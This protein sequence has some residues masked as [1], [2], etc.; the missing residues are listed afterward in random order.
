MIKCDDCGKKFA[1]KRYLDQHKQ[2]KTPCT[3]RYT[4]RKCFHQFQN[5]TDLQRHN[6]RKTPCDKSIVEEVE[7]DHMQCQHC[8]KQYATKGS[9]T[10]HAKNC[11]ARL[12]TKHVQTLMKNMERTINRLE[13]QVNTQQS[14]I[15]SLISENIYV[16]YDDGYDTHLSSML[17]NRNQWIYFIKE[18]RCDNRVK[19]G[20]ANKLKSRLSSLQTGNSDTLEIIAFIQTQDMVELETLFHNNLKDYRGIGEWFN[21]SEEQIIELLCNYRDTGF[22]DTKLIEE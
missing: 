17:N 10:R 9:V 3:T 14:I 5:K 12:G 7:I 8:L 4:C 22:I 1:E 6:K 2:R 21:L 11:N 15:E 20:Y 13:K 19:I 18:Q 16:K